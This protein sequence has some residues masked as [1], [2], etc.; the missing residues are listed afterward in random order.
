MTLML[1]SSVLIAHLQGD[2]A[3]TT[4]LTDHIGAGTDLRVCAVTW[5]G[6]W[7]E[8]VEAATCAPQVTALPCGPR[9]SLRALPPDPTGPSPGHAGEGTT[10]IRLYRDRSLAGWIDPHDLDPWW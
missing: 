10:R 3:C 4:F 7:S 2:S 1:D 9:A 5:A 8:E 6:L